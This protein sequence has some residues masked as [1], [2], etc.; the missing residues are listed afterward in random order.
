MRARSERAHASLSH[1][2]ADAGFA[3]VGHQGT[4]RTP[5]PSKIIMAAK[6]P[7]LRR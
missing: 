4:D 1:F 2:A 3:G 7:D 6:R 5:N